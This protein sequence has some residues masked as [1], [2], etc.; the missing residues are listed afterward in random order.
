[1]SNA[2]TTITIPKKP[3]QRAAWVIYQLKLK[4]LS[5]S[6]LARDVGVTRQALS[7]ALQQPSANIEPLIAT[8]VGV[9]PEDL[10]PER[11]ENGHRLH[12]VRSTLRCLKSA[13]AESKKRG[14]A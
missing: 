8:A 3:A 10:F 1:M 11:F 13:R 7:V 4:G 9:T 12:K 5:L 2:A 6:S 14:A